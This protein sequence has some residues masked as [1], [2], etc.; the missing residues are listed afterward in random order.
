MKT[1]LQNTDDV[2]H[3]AQQATCYIN[4]NIY[5]ESQKITQNLLQ[6]MICID[7]KGR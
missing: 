1:D 3:T 2:M 5:S 4:A 6:K 7:S